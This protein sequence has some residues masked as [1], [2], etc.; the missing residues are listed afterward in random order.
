MNYS[1]ITLGEYYSLSECSTDEEIIHKLFPA[2]DIESISLSEYNS[3]LMKISFLKNPPHISLYEYPITT[4]NWLD[5]STGSPIAEV[6]LGTD[7]ESVTV[8][9]GISNIESFRKSIE[10][11][12]SQF[13]SIFSGSSNYY[14][15]FTNTYGSL[16]LIMR[17]VELTHSSFD[18]VL[19]WPLVKTL[20]IISY[21]I[22][23]SSYESELRASNR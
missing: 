3:Y 14:N 19:S 13:P 12:V 23:R 15:T 20:N 8:S 4:E 7:W 22:A 21:S 5:Y 1:N 18:T 16:H 10:D 2:I 9:K 11:I 17:V 6:V